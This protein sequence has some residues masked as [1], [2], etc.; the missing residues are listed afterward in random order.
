MAFWARWRRYLIFGEERRVVERR[1]F[2]VRREATRFRLEDII[3]VGDRVDLLC[4]RIVAMSLSSWESKI[5]E[6]IA[7]DE[8]DFECSRFL[9]IR[10]YEFGNL[11]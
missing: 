2:W 10:I 6:A 9:A 7:T 3:E 8:A 4:A 11:W 5:N 1:D